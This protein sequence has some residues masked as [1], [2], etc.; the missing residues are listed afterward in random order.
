MLIEALRDPEHWLGARSPKPTPTPK[1]KPTPTPTPNP[2]PTLT[3]DC[4]TLPFEAPALLPG[5]TANTCSGLKKN[6][7]E[8]DTQRAQEQYYEYKATH[9]VS[10]Y[11]ATTFEPLP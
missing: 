6:R 2:T 11:R 10:T 5:Q 9:P 7:L 8:A 4:M 1:P 3:Q